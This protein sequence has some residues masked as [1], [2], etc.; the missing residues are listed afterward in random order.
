MT[1]QPRITQVQCGQQT[2]HLLASDQTTAEPWLQE[3]L[4]A[5]ELVAAKSFKA[6]KRRLD[7]LRGRWLYHQVSPH[8]APLTSDGTG[9]AT[10]P[11]DTR[12]SISHKV[13]NVAVALTDKNHS[14]GIDLEDPR[15]VGIHLLAKIAQADEYAK[16]KHDFAAS[17]KSAADSLA[18]AAIFAGKEAVF[19][20]IYPLTNEFFYFHDFECQTYDKD[21]QQISGI[22]KKNLGGRFVTNTQIDIDFCF[23]TEQSLVLASVLIPS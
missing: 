2:I 9:Q 6:E 19:K 3:Q 22:L 1:S 4:H 23:L 21:R 13:G 7:F 16:L 5:D 15:K 14:V 12:G 11:P 10:W 8:K 17:G 20:A 18:L